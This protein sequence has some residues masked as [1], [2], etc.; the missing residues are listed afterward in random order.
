MMRKLNFIAVMIIA[1]GMMLLA[2]SSA[3]SSSELYF[4]GRGYSYVFFSGSSDTMQIDGLYLDTAYGEGHPVLDINAET[5]YYVGMLRADYFTVE[6]LAMVYDG[7][8][9]LTHAYS[10]GYLGS[11]LTSDGLGILWGSGFH[12]VL[13]AEA[14]FDISQ[15]GGK[16]N[17]D[18]TYEV[19]IESGPST[20]GLGY[21]DM[22][23]Q[24]YGNWYSPSDT[25][26]GYRPA[27]TWD[28]GEGDSQVGGYLQLTAGGQDVDILSS[29]TAP[30]TYIEAFYHSEVPET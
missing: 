1:V 27:P 19:N 11:S 5:G 28:A 22:S 18:L 20:E 30:I 13:L 12:T 2:P 23:V 17:P 15:Y 24:L 6:T 10:D 29:S 7:E 4:E 26:F 25:I 14:P 9:E 8:V 16:S 21:S 3:K